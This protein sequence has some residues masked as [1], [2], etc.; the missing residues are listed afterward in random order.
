[1]KREHEGKKI[2]PLLSLVAS[3]QLDSPAYCIGEQCAWYCT[4]YSGNSGQC[5]M[6]MIGE[7]IYSIDGQGL[8]IYHD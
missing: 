7:S 4:G 5:A 6:R 2:C 8:K 3:S 1:M